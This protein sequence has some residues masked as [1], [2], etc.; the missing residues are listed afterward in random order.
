MIEIQQSSNYMQPVILIKNN[1]S[2]ILTTNSLLLVKGEV[3]SGKSRLLMNLMTGLSGV[4]EG[5]NLDY[6]PCP[7]NLHVIYLSTEMSPYHLQRR[8]L[9]ILS[10]TGNQYAN[11]LKFFDISGSVDIK[12]DIEKVLTQYPPYVLIIDQVGD[13][14]DKV[15]ASSIKYEGQETSETPNFN[16]PENATYKTVEELENLI[17]PPQQNTGGHHHH[18]DLF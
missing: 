14:T 12:K 3:G 8:L 13:L 11:N 15:V 2:E 6:T 17:N 10:I 7:S 16:L 4:Q 18:H 5:L 9:K 1:H